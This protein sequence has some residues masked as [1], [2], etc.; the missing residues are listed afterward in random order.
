MHSKRMASLI[1]S[2]LTKIVAPTSTRASSSSRM[3]KIATP[4]FASSSS[5]QMCSVRTVANA[6]LSKSFVGSVQRSFSRVN[7]FNQRGLLMSTE[8]YDSESPARKQNPP[9][10]LWRDRRTKQKQK[11]KKKTCSHFEKK[12]KT[13]RT[14]AYFYSSWISS[15]HVEKR[16]VSLQMLKKTT[17]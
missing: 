7:A 1:Q 4:I 2:A 10:K 16:H 15:D 17:R 9:K 3:S 14:R 5:M 11:M 12:Q 8:A 6:T 13:K